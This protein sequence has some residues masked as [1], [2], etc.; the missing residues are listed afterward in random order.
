MIS[1]LRRT[2]VDTVWEAMLYL[3]AMEAMVSYYMY[4]HQLSICKSFN[5]LFLVLYHSYLSVA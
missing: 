1:I 4:Y 5:D 2:G 3:A